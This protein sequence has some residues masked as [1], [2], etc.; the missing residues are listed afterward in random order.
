[1][2]RGKAERKETRKVRTR[3]VLIL[4]SLVAVILVLAIVLSDVLSYFLARAGV[5]GGSYRM[6]RVVACRR[7]GR[8]RRRGVRAVA[9]VRVVVA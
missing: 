1:M 2:K 5:N 8:E 6:E 9:F 3:L 7:R 4:S